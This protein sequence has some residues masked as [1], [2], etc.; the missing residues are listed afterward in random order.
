MSLSHFTARIMIAGQVIIVRIDATSRATALLQLR[1]LKK[2][3]SFVLL[4]A[5]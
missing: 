2:Q 3:A 1:G 4:E 5:H